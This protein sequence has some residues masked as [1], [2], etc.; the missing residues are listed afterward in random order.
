VIRSPA[1]LAD[2]VPARR[3]LALT[4]PEGVELPFQIAGAGERLG[5][6][7]VDLFCMGVTLL[8]L[9]ILAAMV[10]VRPRDGWLEALLLLTVF[11][12][13][14]GYFLFFELRPGAATPGKKWLGLRVMD[15]RGGVLTP[16]AVVAR[17]L[18]RNLELHV[19]VMVVFGISDFLP[20]VSALAR[21]GAVA[22]AFVLAGL[23]L[24]NQRR[25]RPG[26]LLGGTVVVVA[27]KPRLLGELTRTPA[28][29]AQAE[30]F[31]FTDK[32]LG[33]YGVYELQVL[34]GLLR[35]EGATPGEAPPEPPVAR[36]IAKKIRWEGE[37]QDRN[38]RRFL[39]DFYAA[40]RQHLE[41]RLLLG[42]R[43]ADK[44]SRET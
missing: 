4:T 31:T 40:L 23:P 14:N 18:M 38:A 44:R 36:K 29:A 26:D 42:K 3:T 19:P 6:F 21:L 10:T 41:R 17:N 9:A 5:A 16:D 15:A 33:I 13:L 24:F 12:L 8:I 30:G 39:L 32:Q 43:K 2:G 35:R 25:L 11:T 20:D 7:L 34:E 27:P 1:P 28:A 22:W 37:L